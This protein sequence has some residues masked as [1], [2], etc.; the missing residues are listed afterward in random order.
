MA[1]KLFIL[2]ATIFVTFQAV[3]LQRK[4]EH[5]E[6]ASYDGEEQP[7]T[8]LHVLFARLFAA[9]LI[10]ALLRALWTDEW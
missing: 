4:H 6:T 7:V 5:G 9:A 3:R 1:N 10:A 2:A 8:K